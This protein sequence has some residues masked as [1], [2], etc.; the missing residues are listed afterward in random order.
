M[1]CQF[2][3]DTPNLLHLKFNYSLEGQSDLCYVMT[4]P[5]QR[6]IYMYVHMFAHLNTKGV[7]T[8]LRRPVGELEYLAILECG[9]V[10]INNLDPVIRVSSLYPLNIFFLNELH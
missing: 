3:A 7:L 5:N 4:L 1:L 6:S 8:P 10:P 2:Q 9:R